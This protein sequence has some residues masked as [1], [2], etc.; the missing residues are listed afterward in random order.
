MSPHALKGG[1]SLRLVRRSSPSRPR[2][3][4][5]TVPEVQDE[6]DERAADLD[7]YIEKFTT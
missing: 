3:L 7:A 4:V 6:I 1:L 5:L 2:F